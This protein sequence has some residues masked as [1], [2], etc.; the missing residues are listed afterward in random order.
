MLVAVHGFLPDN[1]DLNVVDILLNSNLL[2]WYHLQTFYS[3]RIPQG[4]LKYP[5]NFLE[6]IP[7]KLNDLYSSKL[8]ELHSEI[9][10]NI[11]SN[12]SVKKFQIE[13]DIL[14]YNMYNLD[15][16]EVKLIEP[17][18]NLTKKE[19]ESYQLHK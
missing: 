8:T 12:K 19:Y 17:E 14:I 4:S 13:A 1:I 3:Q 10:N 18:F 6:S 5:I 11:N 2:N 15:Y 7:I 9:K 16:R